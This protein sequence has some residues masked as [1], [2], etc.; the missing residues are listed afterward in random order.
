MSKTQSVSASP[1]AWIVSI[2]TG[3]DGNAVVKGVSG[4]KPPVITY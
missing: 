3:T 1:P 2:V 4:C